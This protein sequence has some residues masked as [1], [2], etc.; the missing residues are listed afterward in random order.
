[1]KNNEPLASV[2]LL[3]ILPPHVLVRFVVED[4]H[5]GDFRRREDHTFAVARALIRHYHVVRGKE[6]TM[7]CHLVRRS[8][9]CTPCTLLCKSCGVSAKPAESG[10][11]TRRKRRKRD[12]SGL[13][14]LYPISHS[15]LTN[16]RTVSVA[17]ENRTEAEQHLVRYDIEPTEED[18]EHA[19]TRLLGLGTHSWTK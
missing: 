19:D 1:M 15:L 9:F 14:Q 6:R 16:K 3:Q 13:I 18:E 12:I 5:H 4:V 7:T 17:C 11:K 8:S 10:T 2:D